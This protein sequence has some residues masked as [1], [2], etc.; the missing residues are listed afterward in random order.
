[1]NE[2]GDPEDRNLPHHESS[3]DR[4]VWQMMVD[5]FHSAEDVADTLMR[6]PVLSVEGMWCTIHRGT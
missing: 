6:E 3:D 4:I 5:L 1:M 2:E